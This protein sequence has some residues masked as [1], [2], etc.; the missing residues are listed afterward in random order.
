MSASRA[1]RARGSRV[2]LLIR[3]P[4]LPVARLRV[5]R[6]WMVRPLAA[7]PQAAPKQAARQQAARQQ[8][9]RQQAA[10]LR[11]GHPRTPRGE[12]LHSLQAS[13]QA[14]ANDRPEAVVGAAFV[15]GVL[16]ALVIKRLA[17]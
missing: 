12:L 9:A 6:M 3:P 10:R 5:A 8:A 15:G 2:P 13:L 4:R 1:S 17:D 14:L 16:L 7:F 11:V